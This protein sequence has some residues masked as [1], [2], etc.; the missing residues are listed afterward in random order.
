[1]NQF[2]LNGY[3]DPAFEK[4]SQV[5]FDSFRN[6]KEIGAGVSVVVKGKT[7]VDIWAGYSDFR[8]TK[9]WQKDTLAN[10]FSATK[11]ITAICA[12]RLVQQGKLDLDKPVTEYWPEFIGHGKEKITVRMLLNHQAGMI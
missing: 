8:Q 11:A 9:P 3:C 10:I 12:L 5:F 7:V 4:V 6:K 1:M 2:T